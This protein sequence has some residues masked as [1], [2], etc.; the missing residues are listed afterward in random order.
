MKPL[1]LVLLAAV[2]ALNGAMGLAGDRT[3]PEKH[4]KAKLTCYDCHHQDQPEKA[5]VADDSCVQCHGDF[6]AM[7]EYTRKLPVNPHGAR[8]KGHPGPF[9]CT[10]CHRQH[11]PPVVKCLECHPD[12]K[13]KAK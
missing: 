1:H 13:F 7:A 4:T 3:L 11:K 6:A 9:T 2:L 12:F 8:Q 10:E 5:A